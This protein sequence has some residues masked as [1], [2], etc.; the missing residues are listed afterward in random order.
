MD[1]CGWIDGGGRGEGGIDGGGKDGSM[2]GW[3]GIVFAKPG[4]FCF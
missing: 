4:Y 3:M 1:G 2:D